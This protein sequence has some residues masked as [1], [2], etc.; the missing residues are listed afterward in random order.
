MVK[1]KKDIST[2]YC[3]Q[4]VWAKSHPH[5]TAAAAAAAAAKKLSKKLDAMQIYY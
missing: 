2:L 5:R 3:S 1:T 4:R